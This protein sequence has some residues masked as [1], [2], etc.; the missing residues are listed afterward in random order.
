MSNTGHCWLVQSRMDTL[1]VLTSFYEFFKIYLLHNNYS[2]ID[3]LDIYV[4]IY[5]VC[6]SCGE[7]FYKFEFII[8][9]TII[10][11]NKFYVSQQ[12]VT[13]SDKLK[14]TKTLLFE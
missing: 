1:N 7:Y 6:K 3:K 9:I 14:T 10:T 11:L 2:N 5:C 13:M 12:L 8:H 4:C